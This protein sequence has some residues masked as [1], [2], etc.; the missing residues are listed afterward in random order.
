M[1]KLVSN[2]AATVEQVR[3]D[4][5]FGSD[6]VLLVGITKDGEP[7]RD[8]VWI[9]PKDKLLKKFKRKDKITFSGRE[10]KYLDINTNELTKSGIKSIRDVKCN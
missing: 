8:H 10:Y 1:N 2:F 5:R 9:K 6:R 7:W 4:N 3:Y